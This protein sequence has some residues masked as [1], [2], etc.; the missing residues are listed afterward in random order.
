M[1]MGS[2]LM[3]QETSMSDIQQMAKS[4]VESGLFG[5]KDENQAI[6]LMLIAQAEGMH[7]AL[8]ARDYHIIQ[9]KHS[10]KA[11][12]MLARF[13]QSGGIVKWMQYDDAECIGIFS[14]P[15]SPEPVTVSWDMERAK[16]AGIT[17]N[18]TW[19]KYPRQMLKA[20]VVSDGVRLCFPGVAVG[21]YTPEEHESFGTPR[22]NTNNSSKPTVESPQALPEPKETHGGEQQQENSQDETAILISPKQRGRLFA[23]LKTSGKGKPELMEYL[24]NTLSLDSTTKIPAFLYEQ[25]VDWV[26]G[27]E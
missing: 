7:P 10:L 15:Q 14:H 18:P 26:E 2:E 4:L 3:R 16:Q 9:G 8:A 19:K 1:E 23:I 25:V 20:R 13:Q 6:A 21:V 27:K 5:I 11:D 22:Q 24:Q 12:A 17:G